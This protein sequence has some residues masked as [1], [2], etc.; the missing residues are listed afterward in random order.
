[1]L[2]VCLVSL[3]EAFLS[4]GGGWQTIR[5]PIH[6]D[7]Y[8]LPAAVA[9]MDTLP[10]QRLRELKQTGAAYYVYPGASHNR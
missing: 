10:V 2:F 6:G 9:V 4:S 5:D 3:R 1:M 7:I 8:L